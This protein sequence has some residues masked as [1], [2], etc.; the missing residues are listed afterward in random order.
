MKKRLI[1]VTVLALIILGA[2]AFRKEEY[3]RTTSP[4]G[5]YIAVAE[6]RVYHSWIPRPPGSSS[7]KSGFITIFKKDEM[8]KIGTQNVSILWMIN[9]ITWTK[10]AAWIGKEATWKF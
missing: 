6:Y 2:I 5:Q 3:A 4:D 9:D 1:T 8:K 7:D 10:E